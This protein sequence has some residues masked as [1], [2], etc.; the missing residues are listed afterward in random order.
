ME[1]DCDGT[2]LPP[3]VHAPHAAGMGI[4]VARPDVP[5]TAP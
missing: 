5:H 1:A 3:H 2:A 4:L